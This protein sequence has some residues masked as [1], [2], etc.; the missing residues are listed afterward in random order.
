MASGNTK[1]Q[2]LKTLREQSTALEASI[3]ECLAK[4]AKRPVHR[5]RTST[6]RIE[7]QLQLLALLPEVPSH[8]KPAQKVLRLLK[9][10]RR[11]AGVVRDIDVQQDLV[12]E[13]TP[14][15]RDSQSADDVRK[16][17]RQLRQ[18]LKRWREKHADELVQLLKKQKTDLPLAFKVL[19]DSLE[20]ADSLA[21][22]EADLTSRVRTWYSENVPEPAPAPD[23]I[24][25]LHDIRKQAKLARYLAESAPAS[26]AD[27]RRLASQFEDLQEA[28]GQWHDWLLLSEIARTHLG[29]SAELPQRYAARA[30]KFLK[31]FERKIEKMNTRT[32][33]SHAQAA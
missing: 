29:N 27:A 9:K 22:G 7:A 16:D 12:M 32:A 4:P 1:I 20:D 28:G 30:E 11:A 26:A 5:L 23:D 18:D 2:P 14:K 6:R 8:A 24:E 25:H 19:F 15:K 21:I 10:V 17:A 31:Q 33:R 3:L 13:T